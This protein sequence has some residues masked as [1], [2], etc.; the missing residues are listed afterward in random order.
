[1]PDASKQG[2][3]PSPHPGPGGYNPN[4][5]GMP[6]P[7][8]SPSPGGVVNTFKQQVFN[9]KC[10]G[11]KP[12]TIHKFYYEGVDRGVDCIPVRPKPST[13]TAT[14]GSPLMTNADGE[15]EFK[16]YFTLDVEKQVDA[17]NKVKYE[18]A[19]DKK[20]S[21]VAEDSSAAK[22]VPMSVH[23][24]SAPPPSPSPPSRPPYTP[25]SRDS[26]GSP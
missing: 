22:I 17:S 11:M 24:V 23:Y 8:P 7:T 21:L 5:G 25:P 2:E 3:S 10:T 19:G 13:G 26:H 4:G 9:V 1:M 12:K 20:F 6:M 15:I 14:L 16:F 18:A